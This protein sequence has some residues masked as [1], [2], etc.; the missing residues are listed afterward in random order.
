[1]GKFEIFGIGI[2]S[3][4]FELA[5]IT[6]MEKRITKK[7]FF[8]QSNTK[9]IKIITQKLLQKVKKKMIHF[10]IKLNFSFS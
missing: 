1:M 2:F 5:K 8:I 9:T 6:E 4:K 7:W 3:V 10:L